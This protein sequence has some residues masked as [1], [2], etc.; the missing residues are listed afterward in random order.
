MNHLLG[1]PCFECHHLTYSRRSLAITRK[2]VG[3]PITTKKNRACYLKEFYELCSS[4]RGDRQHIRTLVT[5]AIYSGPRRGEL[6]KLRWSNVAFDLNAINFTETKTNK[7]RSVPMEPI[8]QEALSELRDQA[9]D[10]EYVF[11]NPDTNT[12]YTD[13]KKS[14]SAACREAGITNFTFHDL[15]HTFGTRLAD[16]GVERGE[17]QR[18]DGSRFDCDNR[19]LHSR[20]RSRKAWGDHCFVRLSTAEA[21]TTSQVCHNGKA[22]GP[23]TH[24]NLPQVI[25]NNGEPWRARTSDPLIKSAITGTPAGYGS[26]DLLTFVTGCSRQRVQLLIPI[27]TSL[28]VFWSQVGHKLVTSNSLVS[29]GKLFIHS[30]ARISHQ[31][32]VQDDHYGVNRF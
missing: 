26:Y 29:R 18:V 1:V 32:L 3:W 27:N 17:D 9:G 30:V 28:S 10:E 16:A 19:A 22:A 25:A 12:R 11:T 20:N 2:T 23:M 7:D 14:F 15:R 13:I 4:R 21:E 6:L 31:S 5:V 8:V 24:W